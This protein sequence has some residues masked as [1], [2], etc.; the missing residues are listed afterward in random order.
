M[1]DRPSPPFVEGSIQVTGSKGLPAL[2]GVQGQRP[3]PSLL[4]GAFLLLFAAPLAAAWLL[5][6]LLDWNNYRD[7]IAALAS[8]RL[9]REVRIAGPVSLKLL[10]A[11]V[12][13][14][15]GVS[16]TDAGDGIVVRAAQLRLL[17]SLGSLVTGRIDTRELVLR[18]GEMHVPWPLRP[19]RIAAAAPDWFAA[20]SVRI[21][22]GTLSIGDLGFTGVQAT[23][24]TDALTGTTT[25]A[26]TLTLSARPWHFT[27]RLARAGGDGSA[28]LD[29]SLDGHGPVQG[30]GA[31]LTGQIRGDGGFGGRVT[32]RGPDLSQ[33]LPAP[34]LPFRAEG[35]VNIAGGLATADELVGEIGGSPVKGALVLRVAPAL[36]L[37]L[38]VAASRLD[39]DS[40]LPALLRGGKAPFPA[41]LDLSAEAAPL[42]GGTLR[43]LRGS[44]DISDGTID[45][46]AFKALLPGEA[47]LAATGQVLRG[48]AVVPRFEGE[49][50]LSAPALRGTLAWMQAAGLAPA[51]AL[52]DK[53][54]RQADLTAHGVLEPG[55]LM[56]TRLDGHADGSHVT[57]SLGYRAGERPALSAALKADRVD[58]DA[59]L[60]GTWPSLASI[61]ARLDRI[62]ADLRL[63]AQQAVLLGAAGG[64]VLLDGAVAGGHVVLRRLEVA[65]AGVQ[66]VASGTLGDGGRIDGGRLDVQ[67]PSAAALAGLLPARFAGWREA[68]RLWTGPALLAVQASGPPGA[69]ALLV[70]GDIGDLRLE[71]LR[72]L[73]LGARRATGVLTL[74]H[75]GAPRLAESLGLGGV[76]AWLGDGSLGLVAQLAVQLP[77][78]QAGRVAAGPFNLTAG[79]LRASGALA[80]DGIGDPAPPRLTGRIVAETLPLPAMAPRSSDPLPFGALA[81]WGAQVKLEAAKVMLGDWPVL[82]QAAATLALAEG[83]LRIDGLSARLAEG[84]LT[85]SARID[86]TAEPPSVALE[87]QVEAA[88]LSGKLTELPVD[89]VSG[90]VDAGLSLSASGHA[91]AALL[92]TLAGEVTLAVSDGTLTGVALG[93]A[94][95][96]LADPAV[97]TALAGGTTLFTRLDM[98][99]RARRGVLAVADGRMTGPAG[100]ATLSGSVDVGGNEAEL[101]L[102]LLPAVANPP[103]IG[104]RL[105]G[106]LDALRR[107]PELAGVARWRAEHAGLRE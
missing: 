105:T 96:G 17:V 39:L 44:F 28:G 65:A 79:G 25:A 36:H 100:T 99:L 47:S 15:A 29:V 6:P 64:P 90:R 95:G 67:A 83:T 14:A 68:T 27:A 37:D 51:A 63:E 58:L 59:W 92:A 77:G 55:R 73:D 42:A 11:P 41:D 85:G 89:L 72:V 86:S 53:V 43:R 106:R 40:W 5:P 98:V 9:G 56:L 13:T 34:A 54:L 24:N 18:G 66:A 48:D 7:S 97:R 1:A 2:G 46:R 91:P 35:R 81:G 4:A 104:L 74:R 10:P 26:G 84:Q 8:D 76:A 62:D 88:Q 32:G 87:A 80:L 30:V 50:T 33:L 57:G 12:L 82:E 103:E 31:L 93:G 45:V 78:E 94:Q 19:V 16:L 38:T 20:A 52:P 107:M 69:L 75:P 102:G 21:E 101:R 60:P 22:D 3:W 49:V 61:P 71:T 70:A 23:L